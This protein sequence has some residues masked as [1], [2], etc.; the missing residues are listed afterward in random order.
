MK[1]KILFRA[2]GN[3]KIGLGH[4]Y[5]LFALVEIYKEY[6]NYDFVTRETSATEIIPDS[7]NI[8]I[9]P[10]ELAIL[11]EPKWLSECYKDPK[12][13]IIADGYEYT[14][15]YQKRIKE[16][17]FQLIY[18]DDLAIETLYADCVVNHSPY[19]KP[20]HFC[21]QEYTQLALGLSYAILRPEFLKVAQEK[22]Q[23]KKIDSVFICFGGADFFDLTYKST[24]ALLTFSNVKKIHIILGA[25]YKHNA[26]YDL[27]KNNKNILT[28]H[29]NLNELEL[30]HIMKKSNFGI[31]PS[32]TICY[33]LCS[34]KMPILSG[35]FVDNQELIYKGFVEK[36]VIFEGGNLKNYSVNDFTKKINE[37]F[38]YPKEKYE[39]QIKNQY[40]LFDGQQKERFLSLIKAL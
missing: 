39:E 13:I 36:N 35:Y 38:Q 19:V 3:E 5:R 1:T 12:L 28:L 6:Y 30:L 25:S 11:D 24:Q 31:V 33:E 18:I 10:K 20:S 32:S 16:L 29:S 27:V 14:S 2:D 34:V 9:I 21:K 4:L 7:Y 37:I 22:K 26:I 15:A 40:A 23:I 8:K 17:G